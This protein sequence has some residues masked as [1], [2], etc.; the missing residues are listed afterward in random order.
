MLRAVLMF[1]KV[2]HY[3]EE[4]GQALGEY[5]LII[6]LVVL[7]AVAGLTALGVA[8]SGFFDGFLGMLE[9]AVT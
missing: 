8:V 1:S 2:L 9:G 5:S 4:R 7:A 6:A 3:S